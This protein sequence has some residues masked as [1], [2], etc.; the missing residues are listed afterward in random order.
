[1]PFRDAAPERTLWYDTP[2]THPDE[3]GK[4]FDGVNSPPWLRALPIGN[5][6]LGGMVYGDLPAEFIRLN[7]ES[8][9]SGSPQNSDNPAALAALPEIRRLLFARK[10][11][12]AQKRTYE[13]M[14]CR[15]PG[16]QNGATGQFGSFQFLGDLKIAFDN[17][18]PESAQNYRR[19]L[20]L[21]TATATVDY[22]VGGVKYTREA[23]AS[24]PD[25]ALVVH[26]SADKP[27]SLSFTVT[28]DRSE[29]AHVERTPNGDLVL[30]GQLLSGTE[31]TGG[32]HFAARVRVLCDGGQI[33]F[34][35]GNP[36][37]IRVEGANAAT[38][39]LCAATNWNTSED[40]DRAIA[41]TLNRAAKKSFKSLRADHIK[42]YQARFNRV[43]L[44]LNGTPPETAALPT[45][46]RLRAVQKDSLARDP[47]LATLYF[48]YGRY[49]L[50]ASSSPISRLPANLQ[51][52]WTENIQTPW[53]GD[54]HHN[55]NDQMNYFPA[56][57]GNL[58]DCH[59]PFL[60]FIQSLQTPGE[61]TA[62][63]HYGALGWVVHTI[64]NIWGFTSPGEGASWGQFPAAGAWLCQHLWEHFS[65]GGDTAYLARVYPTLRASTLF[66]LDFLV[67]DP[68]TGY[69]VTAPSNSPENGFRTADG[70]RA[71][72][73]MAPTMDIEILRGL[74][75][76]VIEAALIL[77]TD[78][79]LVARLKN[80]KSKLVPFQIGK[81][82]QLQEWMEDF[83][84]PE[85]GHRHV[86]HLFAL[87][88][89][90]QITPQATP[91]LARAARVSLER[92]LASG[93]GHTGWSRAWIVNFWARLGDGTQAHAHLSLLLQKSTATNLFDMHP[94]FQIDG[95]FGACSGIMEMLLQSHVRDASG[96]YE[97]HLLPALPPEWQSGSVDGLRARGGVTVSMVWEA[98]KIKTATLLS[99]KSQTV[100]VR[101]PNGQRVTGAERQSGAEAVLLPGKKV[102]VLHFS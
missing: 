35:D 76:S 40:P 101:P 61:K 55:I 34:A 86:S 81:H 44:H 7:E 67:T 97:I 28:L 21:S 11:E 30:H 64:S 29:H 92:R 26:L 13:S 14:V 3:A 87:H 59:V 36:A 51:G 78:T 45:D 8:L 98:G 66:Y 60:N 42:D 49:L 57:T 82:G 2:A 16:S 75:A 68:K 5:G 27:K 96:G 54:Y 62:R 79:L 69:L 88:P 91:D 70:Q 77:Q 100:S 32:M 102:I 24:L 93:G 18:A 50:I 37:Q 38:L 9:W 43:R 94:P 48:D 1:M 65:F 85:P 39:L 10:Y 23:F 84:E 72:V 53:N 99:Q 22:A 52:I 47:D 46:A 4:T 73:C 41:E 90:D 17:H 56:E 6:R 71:S 20:H 80:A 58:S 33:V 89:G 15:G 95:N 74:F 12:E 19:T 63:V 31:T 83:D 25:N